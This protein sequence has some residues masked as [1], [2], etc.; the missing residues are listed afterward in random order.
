MYPFCSE[1][2]EQTGNH[3]VWVGLNQPGQVGTPLEHAAHHP[4]PTNWSSS[5][6]SAVS[7]LR[8][9]S[10]FRWLLFRFVYTY[11]RW[12]PSCSCCKLEQ[13]FLGQITLQNETTLACFANTHNRS[14][15]VSCHPWTFS[16]YLVRVWAWSIVSF[17]KVVRSADHILTIVLL[18]FVQICTNSIPL[19]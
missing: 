19:S 6:Q 14:N 4:N 13:R 1:R 11:P 15:V 10:I 5:F 16:S 9:L 8:D 17:R 7:T 3:S 12:G 2:R 18:Y